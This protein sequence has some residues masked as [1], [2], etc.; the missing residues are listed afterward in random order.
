MSPKRGS[1][2]ACGTVSTVKTEGSEGAMCLEIL[3]SRL[4][5]GLF[6]VEEEGVDGW[7]IDLVFV[8]GELSVVTLWAFGWTLSP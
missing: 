7:D 5:D 1:S 2:A 6:V 3:A 8:F 4:E